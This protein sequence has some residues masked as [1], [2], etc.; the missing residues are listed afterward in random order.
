MVKKTIY[1]ALVMAAFG[2]A[3]VLASEKAEEVVMPEPLFA[4]TDNTEEMQKCQK[5]DP[6]YMY[7][8]AEF[9]ANGF[10]PPPA[11]SRPVPN[12]PWYHA[13]FLKSL[14]GEKV[15]AYISSEWEVPHSPEATMKLKPLSIELH[16]GEVYKF[17]YLTKYRS[18]GTMY[19][20]IDNPANILQS[21]EQ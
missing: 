18:T 17:C 1:I 19:V 9:I 8:E 15:S 5:L 20:V 16:S 12:K 13:I 3:A 6:N 11:D 4:G 14:E 2:G 21:A 10:F 7:G